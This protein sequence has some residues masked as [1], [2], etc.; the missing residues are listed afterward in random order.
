[1]GSAGQRG[2]L[3]HWI[4]A[5]AQVFR[6][7][8]HSFF[9]RAEQKSRVIFAKYF[10]PALKNIAGGVKRLCVVMLFR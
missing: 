10:S 3:T 5:V 8:W 9:D 6:Q 1:M 4:D 7:E 2:D